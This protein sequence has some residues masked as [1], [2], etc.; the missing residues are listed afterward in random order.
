MY[1][2]IDVETT[3]GSP[4][5]EKITEIA[6]VVHNGKNIVDEFC[7]LVNPEKKI[8]YFITN[9]TGITNAMV[10]DSP[11]FYEIAKKILELTTDCIFVAHNLSFDYHFIRNEY[12]RL[13]YTFYRDKICTVQLSRKLIPGLNSYN[14]GNIC[15]CLN[16]TNSSRHRAR[17]DT[18]ATVKLF[19]Y[20]LKLNYN[21][22]LY[23]N[24]LSKLN[25]KII[26]PDLCLEKINNLP[27]DTGVYYFF[28]DKNELIYIGKSKN[29]HTR[30]MTHFNNNSEKKAIEMK[31]E[32][33]DIEYELTG[34]ELIALLKES[35]E[36]K[37]HK[38]LYN[39]LQRR[40][41]SQYGLFHHID[42][43]GYICFALRNLTASRETPLCCFSSLKSAK[44]YLRNKVGEFRLC[45]KLC[46]LYPSSGACFHYEIAE[47]NGACI[48]K[49]SPESYNSRAELLLNEQ[50]YKHNCFYILDS[51][52]NENEYAVVKIDNEKYIGYGYIG[53][54]FCS[55]DPELL[56]DCIKKF[57]D[58]RDVQKIIKTYLRKNK[59]VALINRD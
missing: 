2:I 51:G 44:T 24:N 11:K 22:N 36:I 31:T 12:K 53:K 33:A 5:V 41:L 7:S 8:P 38:P 39:R 55:S 19:E 48:G 13:G 17:G 35:H 6:V 32:I 46:G 29:I 23:I 1:A 9:L 14:L 54:D 27:E 28:N 47:C 56:N 3:G 59:Q 37:L 40:S 4:V 34:S 15:K 57:D 30:V 16:I 21:N 52:R 43:N 26:H 50:N 25:K 18:D 20:L 10:A 49:E 42:K 45:N 58:N